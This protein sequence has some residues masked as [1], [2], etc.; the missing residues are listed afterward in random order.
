[1]SRPA[2]T[3]AFALLFLEAALAAWLLGVGG[4]STSTT[5]NMALAL[6]AGL[7]FGVAG[8]AALARRPENRTGLYLAAVGYLWPLNVLADSGNDWIFTI[9]YSVGELAWVPFVALVLAYPTGRLQTGLDRALP[10]ATGVVL[11]GTALLVLLI[12]SSPADGG[13]A[14][15]IA[16]ADL[17]GFAEAVR[18][19][20][21][22]GVVSLL[23]V[24][25]VRLVRRWRTASPALKR[26]IWPVL[27]TAAASLVA[28]GLVVVAEEVAAAAADALRVVFFVAFA[29]I[30]I[31]FLLGILRLRLAR[32]SANEV[33]I[34]LQQGVPLREALAKALR[35][36]SLELVY[37]LDGGRGGRTGW[38]D[39]HG[40][41]APDPADTE[42]RVV[43]LVEPEGRRI[44]ALI[45]DPSLAH[46]P[47]LVDAVSATAG[48]ALHNERLQAELL[49][50]VMLSATLADTVPALLVEVDTEGRVLKLNRSALEASGREE[51]AEARGEFFWRLF[52]DPADRAAMT[53]RFRAAAPDFPATEYE[54]RFTNARGER[55]VVYWRS[56]PVPDDEGRVVSIVAAGLDITERDRLEEEKERERAF[57]N[58]IANNAPSLLC[59]V[60]EHGV[61]QD[62]ATNI[63]FEQTL[64]FGPEDTGGHVFWDRYVA[65]EDAD[66][67]R[68]L[69]QRVV[70]GEI[71]PEHDH[72]WMTADGRR[73]S[74]AWSCTRLPRLDERNLFLIS[75]V[76]V[77]E[78]KE[79]E[80]QVERQRDFLQAVT[81]AVPSFLV[82]VDRNATIVE[83]VTN[84]AFLDV[85]GWA[86]AEIVGR[87]LL[88]LTGQEEDEA[89]RVAIENAANG[90]AQAERESLWLDR[91]G[92]QRVVAWTARPVTDPTGRALVL[93]SGADVTVRRRQEE[94]IRASRAR[95]LRA[96]DEGRR[97][98]E[99][100]LHDGA[101][102]RLV[103]LSVSLRLAEKKLQEDP[104]AAGSLVAEAREE[105]V[106]A[107]D[108]L[109]ELARGIH[110]A[111][112][113]DRGLSYALEAL[114]ARAPIPVELEPPQE[115]LPAP[116]EA[117]AYYVVAESLTNV[118]KY[119][120]ATS[121]V[122]QVARHDGR[123]V[124]TVSD[125]GVG[126][127][128]PV[129]GTGLRGLADRL[130][131]L[132][133]SLSVESPNGRGTS[134]RAEIPLVGAGRPE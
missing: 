40:H 44:A 129:R 82:A 50:E 51:E 108:E 49:A 43:T 54:N 123:L 30:P 68:Q 75:G 122:V 57:L 23:L 90:I 12:D 109:R 78:R 56:A 77:T 96:E 100:N 131:A 111:V 84:R 62:R 86:E 94:E 85:L 15:A 116:V 1:M 8:L 6:P 125:D 105:L 48:L 114:V 121:A 60:D 133:G 11:L 66:D 104:A 45:H 70:A 36:P 39:P 55:L 89:A 127:A 22:V 9:G 17:P 34:A 18:V 106:L 126:G 61:V 93:V 3:L 130:A 52:I 113:T 47:G 103:A 37:W 33:V 134:V 42:D 13:A 38:V 99:R 25:I 35:D 27:G 83:E 24:V 98:L 128:D 91:R 97:K 120:R 58:A 74:V 102:Q 4:E 88:A 29:T 118:A 115:R 112:L 31:A 69:L 132:D 32:A 124:V 53:A 119:A 46:E 16:F 7:V 19:L 28:I 87:S 117:A 2:L 95:I 21:H 10:I 5:M 63:A 20:N 26:L 110:P 41:D 79:R 101:Q 73:L 72:R 81:E 80:L 71:V 107:L 14:S 92:E 64:G 59:L 67:V 65:A 76:D